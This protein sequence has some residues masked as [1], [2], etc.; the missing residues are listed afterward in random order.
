M[1]KPVIGCLVILCMLPAFVQA[2]QTGFG[3]VGG[4]LFPIGQEDQESGF[5]FGMKFR[6][7]LAGPVGFEPNFNF[8]SFGDV[9]IAGAGTRSGSDLKYYGLDLTLGGGFGGVGPKP[10]AFIGGGVTNTKREGD[11]TTN[12]SGWSFGG[13]VAVGIMKNID[14]DIRG[15]MNIAS[16]AES[17]SRKSAALTF[18]AVYFFGQK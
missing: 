2:E 11:R 10:Y 13:G 14:I 3:L 9:T 5:V 8:G 15:R 17:T 6:I 4:P 7:D 16:S 12:K 18:G 1:L